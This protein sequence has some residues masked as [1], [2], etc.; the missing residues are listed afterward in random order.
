MQKEILLFTLLFQNIHYSNSKIKIYS[1]HWEIDCLG[2]LCIL[3]LDEGG[4]QIPTMSPFRQEGDSAAIIN[5]LIYSMHTYI[6]TY[7]IPVNRPESGGTV[8]NFA[9]VSRCPAKYFTCPELSYGQTRRRGSN[10]HA[11]RAGDVYQLEFL[12]GEKE[13]AVTTR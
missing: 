3:E 2:Y 12:G 1:Q 10:A 7:I 6:H 8:L 11:P 13:N 9:A 4:Y 5:I